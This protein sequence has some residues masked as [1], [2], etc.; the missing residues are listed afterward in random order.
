MKH[1]DQKTSWGEKG[2]SGL[3]FHTIVHH[4][5]KSGQEL[6]HGWD[7]KSRADAKAVEKSCLLVCL[8]NKLSLSLMSF[9]LYFLFFFSFLCLFVLFFKTR[10]PVQPSLSV[11]ELT[12]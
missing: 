5:R 2:L 9:F 11:L 10:F 3:H 8:L 1:Y 4:Q 7:L 6:K 12:L